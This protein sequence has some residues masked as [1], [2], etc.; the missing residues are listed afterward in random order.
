VTAG[1]TWEPFDPVRFI[2]NRST[3]KMGYAVAAAAAARGAEVV[4][5]HGPTSLEPPAGVRAVAVES[6]QQMLEACL[7][8]FPGC[9]IAVAA[10]APADY[11]PA[12]VASEKIKKERDELT[13]TLVKNPDIIAE[14]GRRK[15]PGQVTV[16]FAA[17]TEN[18]VASA[19]QKLV[20][21]NADFVVANDVTQ[22]GAGFGTETNRVTFVFPDGLEE[23]PLMSKREVA[24]R[25]LDR[26]AALLGARSDA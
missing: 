22:E 2:G 1:T 4:L 14:L 13:I 3:G 18:L 26:A 25:I 10:A 12:T 5:V 9:D 7:R 23:L 8:E 15:R 16:A 19:R 6:C 24:D 17:E 11:R 21:K 20:S